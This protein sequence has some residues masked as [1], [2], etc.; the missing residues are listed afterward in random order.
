[1]VIGV[2]NDEH[3]LYLCLASGQR[4]F[5]R[6]AM[7]LGLILQVGPKG[8]EPIEIRFPVGGMGSG[9]PPDLDLESLRGGGEIP[10]ELW[11]QALATFQVKRPGRDVYETLDVKSGLGIE[12][13]AGRYGGGLAYEL[14]IPLRS[15][16]DEPY[17]VGAA[18]GEKLTLSVDTPRPDREA[19]RR[20]MAGRDGTSGHG[21][22]SGG[23]GGMGSMGGQ[24][25]G[26]GA[27]MGGGR[28][29]LPAG[30][31]VPVRV[32][33]RVQLAPGEREGR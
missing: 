32:R 27:G 29:E 4:E 19:A 28:D 15:S 8:G 20:A 30:G 24:G 2:R 3:H 26:M 18:K 25:G 6:K 12:I 16:A 14:K 1:M 7:G 5:A 23:T 10:P 11:D 21:G 9:P 33:A 22:M 13:G 31:P 17:A